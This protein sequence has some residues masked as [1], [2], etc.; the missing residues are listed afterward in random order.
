MKTGW[1]VTKWYVLLGI[2]IPGLLLFILLPTPIPYWFNSF[3]TLPPLPPRAACYSIRD[4]GAI[5]TEDALHELFGRSSWMPNARIDG[6]GKVRLTDGNETFFVDDKTKG[7]V[8]KQTGLQ[9]TRDDTCFLSA[10]SN[11]YA[12]IRKGGVERLY[13]G[14]VLTGTRQKGVSGYQWNLFREHLLFKVNQ[15][16]ETIG[17]AL[18]ET[19]LPSCTHPTFGRTR[20]MPLIWQ[21]G[22]TS[23]EDL[24]T[25][26]AESSGW[27]L[28]HVFDINDRGQILCMARRTDVKG[29]ESFG[30]TPRFH[31]VIL[32]PL[33]S[34]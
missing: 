21:G 26:I 29:A 18:I 23:P 14:N 17:N 7:R 22:N 3:R 15:R 24:N 16:G 20:G 33:S 28:D 2:V 34:R 10:S 6:A 25:K 13:K 12:L 30:S 1:I 5:S 27:Y 32:T 8:E 31:L 4:S 19:A 11:G 9:D